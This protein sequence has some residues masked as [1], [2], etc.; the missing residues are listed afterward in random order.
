VTEQRAAIKKLR[1]SDRW[2][3]LGYKNR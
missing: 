1:M 2:R 3:W